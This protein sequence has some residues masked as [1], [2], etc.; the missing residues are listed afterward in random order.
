MTGEVGA[1][2]TGGT[3]DENVHWMLDE[4]IYRVHCSLSK[5]ENLCLF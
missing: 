2:V 1:E 4:F 3:C 5:P